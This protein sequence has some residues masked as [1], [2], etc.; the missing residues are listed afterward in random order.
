MGRTVL[1]SRGGG[2]R[3]VEGAI[4]ASTDHNPLILTVPVHTRRHMLLPQ[5]FLWHL[6]LCPGWA[7]VSAMDVSTSWEPIAQC[8]LSCFRSAGLT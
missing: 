2:E 5:A 6:R 8:A 3:R 4:C 1:R 7:R